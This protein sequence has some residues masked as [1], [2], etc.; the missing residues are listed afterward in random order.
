MSKKA[1]LTEYNINAPRLNAR[2]KIALAADIHERRADDVLEHIIRSKPDLI[3]VAGDTFE[4]YSK[5]FVSD[6][7]PRRKSGV[8][9]SAFMTAVHYANLSFNILFNR[10]NR[11]HSE[12][13]YRF[14]ANA[15]QCAPVYVSLGN[16]EQVLRDEDFEFFKEN[17]IHLLDNSD[18]ELTLKGQLVRIGGYS[19]YGNHGFFDAF[20]KKDGYKILLLHQPEYYDELKDSGVD[21]VLSGHNHG[22]QIRVL[23]KGLFSSTCG[24]LPKYD[25]GVFENRLVVTAGCSNTVSIPRINNPREAVIIKLN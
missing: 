8:L 10:N 15:A 21:L 16:H 14:L 13:S 25:R 12:N 4:R 7:L 20:E 19:T 1:V 9:G 3:V 6:A 23:G 11:P 24:F 22:G 18:E 5:D 17:D 2:L